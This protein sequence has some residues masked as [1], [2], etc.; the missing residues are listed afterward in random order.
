MEFIKKIDWSKPG[1]QLAFVGVFGLFAF[2]VLSGNGLQNPMASFS[3]DTEE[4]MYYGDGYAV[5]PD[6]DM[7]YNPELSMRNV[8]GSIMPP[9]PEYVPG[10]DAEAYEVKDYNATIETRNLEEDCS[11]VRALMEREEVI[12]QNKNQY[13]QGC[14]YSFKVEKESV[15][16]VLTILESLDPKDLSENSYTIKREVADYTSEIEIL[17]KKLATLDQTLTDSLASYDALSSQ[18][19]A[20]GDVA[21]LAQI[22]DSKITLVERLT[23]TRIDT[24]AQLDRL[25]RA[26]ADSL[27]RLVYTNFYV[28]IYE[29][30]F[31]NGEEIK[32]S[33]VEAVKELVRDINTFA[34]EVSLGFVALLFMVV[35]Y[36]LYGVVLLFVARF[37]YSFARKVWTSG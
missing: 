7:G 20:R 22:T 27:D 18:A 36:S 29:N 37:A 30:T 9:V 24:V 14:S 4:A 3:K 10:N 32:T 25:A 5:S 15:E 19:T 28:H 11:T 23:I 21:T 34:Q 16:E 8:E 6:M 26:K 2:I 17:E 35:K 1:I 31:V 13:E 33:W 12:F